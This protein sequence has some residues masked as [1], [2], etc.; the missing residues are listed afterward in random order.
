MLKIIILFF[1]FS[2]NFNCFSSESKEAETKELIEIQNELQ[3]KINDAKKRMEQAK[4]RYLR[5]KKEN[6][7]KRLEND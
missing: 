1:C 7:E 5:M 4:A 2:F 6:K 3:L